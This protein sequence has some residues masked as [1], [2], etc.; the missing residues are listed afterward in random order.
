M[1]S[2]KNIYIVGMLPFLT[3]LLAI[4]VGESNPLYSILY[5]VVMTVL[6]TVSIYGYILVKHEDKKWHILY[7]VICGNLASFF[8]IVTSWRLS[9]EGIFLGVSLLIAYICTVLYIFKNSKKV[10]NA[11]YT[12]T[13]NGMRFIWCVII[14]ICLSPTTYGAARFRVEVLGRNIDFIYSISF[15]ASAI[16]FATIFLSTVHKL[17]E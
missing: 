10:A 17:K 12:P 7:L 5:W 15:L 16:F 1:P 6:I 11:I 13:K 14:L 3:G 9:G 2:K 8:L 4:S